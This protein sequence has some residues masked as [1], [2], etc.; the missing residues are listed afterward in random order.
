MI[1]ELLI[2]LAS[3]CLKQH[4]KNAKANSF[5]YLAEYTG[6]GRNRF[7]IACLQACLTQHKAYHGMQLIL[8]ASRHDQEHVH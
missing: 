6:H 2:K 5:T 7:M 1:T 8:A 3:T 4:G